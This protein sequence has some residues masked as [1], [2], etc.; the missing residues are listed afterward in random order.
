MI[1]SVALWYRALRRVER[2]RSGDARLLREAVRTA[3]RL[4][5]VAGV[6]V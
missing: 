2:R 3:N 4:A 6:V 1:G 5:Y